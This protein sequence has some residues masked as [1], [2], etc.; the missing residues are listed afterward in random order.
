MAVLPLNTFRTITKELTATAQEIYVC[1]TGV[2][3]IVLLAQVANVSEGT[4]FVTFSH[5]RQRT[6]TELVKNSPIPTQDARAVLTGRLVLEEGDRIRVLSDT[7]GALKITLS[8][9]ESANQ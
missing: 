3:G 6:E 1:P 2:T 4:A 7:N 5:M 8:L 9:V